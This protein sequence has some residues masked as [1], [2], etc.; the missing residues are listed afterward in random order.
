MS[1][2]AEF[3]ATHSGVRLGVERAR[4]VQAYARSRFG[5]SIAVDTFAREL[6]LLSD[7]IEFIEQ[8]IRAIDEAVEDAMAEFAAM[9]PAMDFP[10]GAYR[11]IYT[12]P[13]IGSVLIA[14]IIGETGDIHWFATARKYVV[15]AG[16]DA[17]VRESGQSADTCN[18]TSKRGSPYLWPALWLAALNA[19]RFNPELRT[20]YE[21]QRVQGK[22]ANVATVAVTRRAAHLVL[23]I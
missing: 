3:L 8:Q 4:Q 13:H 6:K 12:I 11:V 19:R 15:F 7:Q 1:E 2:V 21:A 5:I 18:P 17:M 10:G 14:S 22:H 23:D 20:Y 16:L 9:N